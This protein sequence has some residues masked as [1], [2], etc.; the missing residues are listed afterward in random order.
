MK[1]TVLAL[2]LAIVMLASYSMAL[3]AMAHEADMSLVTSSYVCPICGG[4]QTTT[5][6]STAL[7]YEVIQISDCSIHPRCHVT[8][9]QDAYVI[10][11]Y[12]CGYIHYQNNNHTH[13]LHSNP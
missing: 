6:C 11:C 9:Y 4:T 10:A 1:K 7:H 12:D 8:E 5:Y 2:C 3:E 13:Y